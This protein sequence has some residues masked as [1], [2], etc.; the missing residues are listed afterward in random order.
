M[1]N[2]A[3]AIKL[4][5]TGWQSWSWKYFSGCFRFPLYNF[6]PKAFLSIPK[7]SLQKKQRRKRPVKGWCSWYAFEKNISEK[8]IL[9]HARWL[10]KKKLA[11]CKTVLIDDGWETFWGDWLEADTK[12]FRFGLKKTAAKIKKMKL[13]PGI[14]IAPFLVDPKSELVQTHPEW[15]VKKYGFF[16]EG[17]RL[18]H[19]DRF[20][21]FGKY[22]LD[23]RKKEVVQYLEKIIDWLLKDCGFQVIKLDFLYGIYFSPY[24]SMKEADTFLHSFLA[25]IQKKYPKVYTIGCGCPL[26][27]AVGVV[28]SMRIGP[29]IFFPMIQ[30]IP[31]LKKWL[32]HFLMKKMILGIEQRL[33]TQSLWNIDADVFFCDRNLG[34]SEEKISFWGKLLKE[35]KGNIFLA[36]DLRV[37]SKTRVKKFIEPLFR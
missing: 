7:I 30:N 19:F 20:S 36:D 24:L 2:R 31:F 6:P 35:T 11:G 28:D 8:I 27:P 3:L 21:P 9:D 17:H 10:K 16:V 25:R 12:K 26:V 37:L 14:W 18:T 13:K 34:F 5:K 29:D 22:I 23:V 32:N 1:S 33:W 15:L 4:L